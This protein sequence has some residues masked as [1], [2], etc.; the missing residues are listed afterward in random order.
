MNAFEALVW[1]ACAYVLIRIIK[2]TNE[3]LWIWFGLLAG[4][5]LENK[6]S[7]LIWGTATTAGL[8]L[9]TQR[10]WFR[11]RWIWIAGLLAFHIF[12]SKSGVELSTSLPLFGT[13]G[14]YPS[15]RP[16]RRAHAAFV[17][18][19]GDSVDASNDA[20]DLAGR[21]LVLSIQ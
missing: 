6:H 7:M 20:S 15:Q 18:W 16:Q 4:I 5:G 13:T 19:P 10:Q 9:T 2:T 3:K 17:F 14:K 11:T 21:A 8:L 12:P 1:I